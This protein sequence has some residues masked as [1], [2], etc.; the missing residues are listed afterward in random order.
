MTV[1][2]GDVEQWQTSSII[3]LA[4]PYSF[5]WK[6]SAQGVT[7]VTWQV[8]DPVS[9]KV[10]G[11][12]T[13]NGPF[14]ATTYYRLPIDFKPILPA[15]PDD[16]AKS[17]SVYVLPQANGQNIPQSSFVT[18]KYA[19]QDGVVQNFDDPS[20]D[21][22]NLDQAVGRFETN[23]RAALDGK[24]VGYQYAIYEGQTLKKA[25]AGGYANLGAK[26]KMTP[27]QRMVV[28]SMSKTITAAAVMR[29]LEIKGP[30]VTL[31]SP[32]AP[33][34]PSDWPAPVPGNH[35]KDLTFEDLLQHKSGF[36]G[37]NGGDGSFDGLKQAWVTGSTDADWKVQQ[38]HNA[39]YALFR[40]II[41]YMMYGQSSVEGG[42]DSIEVA[43]G[44]LYVKFVRDNVL[45]PAGLS[46]VSVGSSVPMM[47]YNAKDP[48]QTWG[49]YT[50]DE[51]ITHCGHNYWVLSAKEYGTFVTALQNG[52]IVKDS[53][54]KQMEDNQ[55]G[56]W[57]GPA[58]TF[59]TT[60]GSN[61]NHNGFD[62]GPN[63]TG[64]QGD[65]MILPK[66]VTVVVLA[67]SVGRLDPETSPI[68]PPAWNAA[69]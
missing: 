48:S 17:Y 62:P 67:N 52:K 64:M 22:N 43:T 31:K 30:D 58:P 2:T 65:W 45:T 11:S 61:W 47:Y 7:G 32:V 20:F 6:T 15:Q 44:K 9:V 23:L 39:N 57:L 53:T 25:G 51:G 21:Q 18:V 40:I 50:V 24:T 36:R 60:G 13:V 33:Y 38:Y 41:P 68:I 4:K 55:L 37:A 56:M 46:S 1:T 34:L 3:N 54:F 14:Q 42:P 49:G 10:I 5:R 16:P 63:G 59:T 29:A 26:I 19:K 69:W 12:G 28:A 8:L 66:G 35:M 27:D